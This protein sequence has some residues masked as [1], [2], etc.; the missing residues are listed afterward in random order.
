MN[1][2]RVLFFDIETAP[3]QAYIWRA[4]VQYV[5][6]DMLISDVYLLGW[7][8]KWM[9]GKRLM[10]GYITPTEVVAQDDERIVG[11]LADLIRAAD[12][13]VAHNGDGF[14][15]PVLNNRVLFHQQEPLGPVRSIDTLK[16]ARKNF[17]LT[18]NKLDHL[19]DYLKVGRKIKTD[20]DLWKGCLAGD[21]AALRKMKRYNKQDV[22]LLE[23]VFEKMKPYV[24]NLPR[25]FDAERES[26]RAC[27]FCGKESLIYRGY[28]RTQASTFSQMQCTNPV[29]RRYTRARIVNRNKKIGVH[30]L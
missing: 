29:C 24:R 16:L 15:I 2:L 7:A 3:A 19:A 23:G 14:D 10:T 20:M 21:P 9:G 12:T 4:D 1:P 5:N 27:P 18:Y 28:Y 11:E 8:A 25:L 22:L 30:P 17:N 6:M 26:E 13:V